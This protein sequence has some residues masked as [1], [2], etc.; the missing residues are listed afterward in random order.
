MGEKQI[1]LR[2]VTQKFC[3]RLFDITKFSLVYLFSV[4]IT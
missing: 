2:K 3:A 1:K 4:T